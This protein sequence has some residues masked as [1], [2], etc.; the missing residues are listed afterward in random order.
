MS[1]LLEL[2]ERLDPLLAD[3]DANL[4]QI[5]ELFS[6]HQDLA[7]F[8]VARF[9]AYRLVSSR[10]E[11]QLH[12]VDPQVRR[13]ALDMVR[14]VF[15]RAAASRALRH[16]VKD[17]D[18]GVRSHARHLVRKLGLDDV[19]LPDTN[20]D[21][22][23]WVPNVIRPTTVGFWNPTGWA[24]GLFMTPY[25]PPTRADVLG[26][27]NLPVIDSV[28]DLVSFLNL[29]SARDLDLLRRPDGRRTG[30][31]TTS[32]SP[33]I[34]FSIPK[35]GGG[36]RT[37]A[38]PTGFLKHVQRRILREIL[39]KIPVHEAAHGF[40]KGRSIVTNAEPHQEAAV[41]IKMDLR[42]FFPTIHFRRIAG[43]F[44]EFGYSWQVAQT[45]ASLVT[46]RKRFSDDR[47][48][49]PGILPQGAPTSP[50]IANVLCW[51]MDAR[52]TGLASKVG[53][54]Y[55]RYAD[56]LTFS[57]EKNPEDDGVNVGRFMWWVDQICQQEGFRENTSK[58][59]VLRRGNQQRV[60]GVIVN[61]GL[62]VPRKA[63]RRFR[64]ILENCRRNGVDAEA[65]GHKNF[66]GYLRGFAAYVNMV[67]PQLGAKL[68][69]EV[70]D[71]LA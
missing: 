5:G 32:W 17:A 4:E 27:N 60:T 30:A 19:A 1:A 21:L 18:M 68:V 9:R 49:W 56:D 69:A 22:G 8:Q 46:W 62:F 6:D 35:A 40:V 64:A 33:Y 66:R 34:E 65:R 11:A 15:P 67:Q 45:L 29:R 51:R 41:V 12:D 38:A 16:M 44:Q 2:F 23:G 7:E 48:A 3:V 57:F 61:S 63:R 52:L 55:T 47:V 20:V 42:D 70:E 26:Q 50:A 59:R 58:R 25:E 24:F 37:I 14:T 54:R 71:L 36:T 28:D 10:V 31:P 13:R 39:E 43:M 53:A